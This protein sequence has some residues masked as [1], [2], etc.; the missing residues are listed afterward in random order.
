MNIMAATHI[1]IKMFLDSQCYLANIPLS[2]MKSD[3][4]HL[5]TCD[6]TMLQT[7][8]IVANYVMK[9]VYNHNSERL[10]TLQGV[11]HGIL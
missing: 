2:K 5:G 10:N 9:V 6:C 1:F 4:V 8:P 7:G 11:K 3:L